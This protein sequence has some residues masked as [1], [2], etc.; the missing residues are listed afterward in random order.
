MIILSLIHASRS[1]YI[2]R[3][4]CDAVDR[5]AQLEGAV[6]DSLVDHHSTA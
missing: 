3:A 4:D 5:R 1:T 2:D 6:D